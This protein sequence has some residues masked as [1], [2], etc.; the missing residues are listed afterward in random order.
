MY[1]RVEAGTLRKTKKKKPQISPLR[2]P[3]FA[4]YPGD[5][6]KFVRLSLTRAASVVVVS[7]ARQEIRVRSG[8]DEKFAAKIGVLA[9]NQ[10]IAYKVVTST[11]A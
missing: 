5:V 2:P 8:R 4:A 10:L 7:A 6:M 9:G 3:G 1:V 11:G